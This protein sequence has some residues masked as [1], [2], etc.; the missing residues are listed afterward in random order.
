MSAFDVAFL[1]LA[2]LAVLGGYRLG[3]VARVVSW[4]GLAKIS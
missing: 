2:V 4:V 1:A 3:F